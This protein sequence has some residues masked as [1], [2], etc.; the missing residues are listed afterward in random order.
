MLTTTRCLFSWDNVGGEMLEAALTAI[1]N[2][3]RIIA[4]GAISQYN[5]PANEQ[6]GIKNTFHV[7]AKELRWEGF[8]ILH[9]TE[10]ADADEFFSEFP[11]KI[12]KGEIKVREHVTKGIDNGEAFVDMLSGKAQGKSVVVFE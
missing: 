4:C 2:R 1:N 3:G 10:G 7:V 6:Y 8:I 9:H 12:A 5:K 11:H